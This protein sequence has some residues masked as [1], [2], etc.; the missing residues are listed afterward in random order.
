MNSEYIFKIKQAA[1]GTLPALFNH[2]FFARARAL[3]LIVKKGKEGILQ[4]DMWQELGATSRHGSRIALRLE[5]RDLIT[6]ERELANGRWTYR[7][8]INIQPVSID[9][10]INIPCMV[11]EDI[12]LCEAGTTVSSFECE[13]LT[14]WLLGKNSEDQE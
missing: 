13:R 7:I 3:R 8:V 14:D 4:R 9:S 5:A 1:R 11:C 12:A 10:I 2:K 6:R